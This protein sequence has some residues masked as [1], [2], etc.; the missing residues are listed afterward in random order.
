MPCTEF[1]L[2]QANDGTWTSTGGAQAA[3]LGPG[4][5]YC[6]N[7]IIQCT[8]NNQTKQYCNPGCCC[9]QM[10]L[11]CDKCRSACNPTRACGCDITV[12]VSPD[13]TPP[14]YTPPAPT[15]PEKPN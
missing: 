5:R 2:Q 9:Q 15:A 14:A 4:T 11:H 6:T 10:P 7:G 3:N 12:T 1:V 13:T 8:R